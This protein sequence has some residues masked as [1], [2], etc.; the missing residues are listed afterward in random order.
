M[1]AD[2]QL[3]YYWDTYKDYK[4]VT[5]HP[6][7]TREA[8]ISLQNLYDKWEKHMEHRKGI[9]YFKEYCE[10]AMF[11]L[12][13]D[14]DWS[15]IKYAFMRIQTYYLY[16]YYEEGPNAPLHHP[17]FEILSP[18]RGVVRRIPQEQ[19]KFWVEAMEY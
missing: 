16:Y 12:S 1:I 3:Q 11:K 10:D 5:I 14:G 7:G 18:T 19:W 6:D 15:Y 17:S 4:L 8:P 9:D 13:G 2:C